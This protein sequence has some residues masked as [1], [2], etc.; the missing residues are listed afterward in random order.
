MSTYNVFLL[1]E[2]VHCWTSFHDFSDFKGMQ[3]LSWVVNMSKY[4]ASCLKRDPLLKKTK[5][6]II[7]KKTCVP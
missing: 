6:L 5:T 2:G 1:S 3:I 4:F 7:V